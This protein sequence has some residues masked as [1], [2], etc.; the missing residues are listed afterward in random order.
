MV[1]LYED[2]GY[3]GL[4]PLTYFRPTF[5]LRCGIFSPL[6]RIRRLY[7]NSLIYLLVRE[8]LQSLVAEK[9]P[10]YG[11]SNIREK[12]GNL[13]N[14]KMLFLSGQAILLQEIP[15]EGES[16]IF[17]TEDGDL[18]G[19]RIQI[20][21]S[22]SFAKSGELK[23]MSKPPKKRQVSA[24]YIRNLWDLITLNKKVMPKDFPKGE[25]KG[26]L[27][28]RAIVIGDKSRL[29]IE[30]GAKVLPGNVLNLET[31]NI[32]IDS[33]AEIMPFS[34]LE[35]PLYIGKKTKVFGAKIRPFSN[36]GEGCRIGGEI[37]A[38]IFQGWA[39]KYHEGFLGHSYIGEW[40]NLGAG[41]NNSDLKNNYQSV[42]IRLGRKKVDTGLRKLGCF[43]GDHTKTAI[44]TQIPTGAV[45]GIF[46]NIVEEGFSPNLVPNF[47]W[48]K[49]RRWK[50][51]EAIATTRIVMERR[52]KELSPAYEKLIRNLY[53]R[54]R[55]G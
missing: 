40:V 7:K 44:G 21:G 20:S 9:Y 23:G 51:E 15:E 27:D 47:Y 43:I 39:N 34:Y 28:E 30:K 24:F 38:T 16:E 48:G 3:K 10:E 6:E 55:S 25:I 42:K 11:I 14:E 18:V 53:K 52:G 13:K 26:F 32:Y 37:E 41:T 12:M 31:G 19:F 54:W 36:I 4:L 49:R 45:I 33:E 50:I 5:E 46:A 8:D 22:A 29:Y 1:I 35:G 17:V 2:E